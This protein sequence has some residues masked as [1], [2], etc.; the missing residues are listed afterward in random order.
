MTTGTDIIQTFVQVIELLDTLETGETLRTRLRDPEFGNELRARIEGADLI[1]ELHY[2]AGTGL[3]REC[4]YASPC[5][6]VQAIT[7]HGG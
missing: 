2:D 6:S 3:C 1:H 4:V 7:P 5:P